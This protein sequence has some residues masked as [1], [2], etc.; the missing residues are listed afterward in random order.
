MIARTVLSA[1]LIA[2]GSTAY[3]FEI[4]FNWDGLK[5][6]NTGSPNTVGNP[7]FVLQDVPEGTNF[8][9][10]R[11]VDKNVPDYSHGGGTVEYRGGNTVAPGQFKY[12]SP[13]PPGGSHTYEWTAT[14]QSK[15][16]GGK[17]GV[18]KAQRKYPD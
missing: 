5:L 13:C 6:C 17:L 1:M 2:V 10:F 15:K 3:A 12:Q 9:K 4:S 7:E 18:A 14:A 8:I 16:N 11:L